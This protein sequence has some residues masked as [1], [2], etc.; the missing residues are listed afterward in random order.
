VLKLAIK[1]GTFSTIFKKPIDADRELVLLGGINVLCGLLGCSGIHWS[2][3]NTNL[4]ACSH[5][6]A[7][8]GG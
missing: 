7:K 4:G 6:C 2:F 5:V 8:E 3:S 1:A